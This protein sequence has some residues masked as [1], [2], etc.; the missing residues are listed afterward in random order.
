MHDPTLDRT[1]NGSGKVS[2]YT[3]NE[4]R[5]L[6]L[7]DTYGQLTNENIPTFDEVL[8]W[9]KGKTILIVDMKD[10]PVDIRAQKIRQHHAQANAI[11]MAYGI[12]DAKRCY[13]ID[14]NIMMEVFIGDLKAAEEFDKSG[15]PWQNVVA[16]VTHTE[17]KDKAVFEYLHNKGV[18]GIR[19]SSRTI[20]KD[21]TAGVIAEANMLN[22][23][24]RQL[25]NDGADIIE[26]DLGVEAGQ[27]IAGMQ[28]LKSSKRHYFKMVR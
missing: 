19:G 26:A 25:I 28:K 13:A 5:K 6:K 2:D 3:L 21:Y 20:D 15:V 14:K 7:K 17:P 18:M 4:I 10:V 9:A 27:A 11:I 24:Y 1:S 22:E 8:E 23:K 16:F 12:A